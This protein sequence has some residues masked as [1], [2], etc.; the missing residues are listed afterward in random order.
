[1]HVIY[2]TIIVRIVIDAWNPGIVYF[3]ELVHVIGVAVGVISGAG[4]GSVW[5][6]TTEG[7]GVGK[8]TGIDDVLPEIAMGPIF[9]LSGRL[10]LKSPVYPGQMSRACIDRNPRVKRCAGTPNRSRAA[11]YYD[12]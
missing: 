5:L 6:G 4:S 11:G 7:V 1:M 2:N 9:L 10:A 3:H 12:L 8:D